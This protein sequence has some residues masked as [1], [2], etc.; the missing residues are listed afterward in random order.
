[1]SQKPQES[2][3][4]SGMCLVNHHDLN[5]DENS[6]KLDMISGRIHLQCFLKL[7]VIFKV[8]IKSENLT[9][10]MHTAI[11]DSM[12]KHAV[13]TDFVLCKCKYCVKSVI[14]VLKVTN[15]EV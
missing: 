13:L 12:Y 9:L 14:D 11:C 5:L 10:N 7:N 4:L 6:D 8:P 2:R 1:M 3:L 15:D